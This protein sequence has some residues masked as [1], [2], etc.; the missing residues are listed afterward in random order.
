MKKIIM[1]S[2]AAF[3]SSASFAHYITPYTFCAA[4]DKVTLNI[5]NWDI[6]SANTAYFYATKNGSQDSSVSNPVIWRLKVSLSK[7]TSDI[8]NDTV[9]QIMSNGFKIDVPYTITT[10]Y[11][12]EN[13]SGGLNKVVWSSGSYS[14]K[15]LTDACTILPMELTSFTAGQNGSSIQFNW[16][17]AMEV[18]IDHYE[19][20][21]VLNDST[22]KVVAAIAS[23]AVNGNSAEP[24][25]YELSIDT[26]SVM[27]AGFTSLIMVILLISLI[28]SKKN[29]KLFMPA[30]LIMLSVHVTSCSKSEAAPNNLPTDQTLLFKLRSV[31]KNGS[32]S[33]FTT[34][35]VRIAKNN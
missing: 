7:F 30:L 16:Q 35:A 1:L 5:T 13:E 9:G 10:L 12:Y 17:T 19:I 22:E 8:L 3:I 24:L 18:N 26:K 11:G 4:T 33:S 27:T 14:Y 31:D 29:R 6:G 32:S 2:V 34:V 15:N 25:S 20:V 23:K 21:Q 28:A